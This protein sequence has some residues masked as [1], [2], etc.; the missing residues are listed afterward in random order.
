MLSSQE[1]WDRW[2]LDLA[3]FVSTKSKDP[4]TK[5]GAVIVD[6]NNR[7]VSM[8]FNGLPQKIEDT[9]ERLNNREL[10]YKLTLHAEMNSVIFAHRDLTDCTVYTWPFMSCAFCA[11]VLIQ[12]GIIRCVSVKNDNP[13]WAASFELSTELFKEAGVELVLY[14]FEFLQRIEDYKGGV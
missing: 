1:N 10:K 3:K 5:V 4:S 8:G 12:S 14:D 13:R 11:N 2:F 6:K 7:P 9:P